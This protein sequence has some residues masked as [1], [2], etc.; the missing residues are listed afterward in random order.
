MIMNVLQEKI[1]VIPHGTHLVEHSNKEV[2]KEKYNL[3]GRKIIS[4]FGLL[5]SGK[6]Y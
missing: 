6:S 5:S 2:L 4:T 3:S 1:T